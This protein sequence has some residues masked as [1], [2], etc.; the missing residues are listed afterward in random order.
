MFHVTLTI[1]VVA[2]ILCTSVKAVAVAFIDCDSE[3]CVVRA[4]QYKRMFLCKIYAEQ[5]IY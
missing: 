3:Y 4:E 1:Y 2:S 5:F